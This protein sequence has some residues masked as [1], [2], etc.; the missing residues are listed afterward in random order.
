MGEEFEIIDEG[1][2]IDFDV[3][4]GDDGDDCFDL[5]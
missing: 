1:I 5:V 4:V 2:L 3:L